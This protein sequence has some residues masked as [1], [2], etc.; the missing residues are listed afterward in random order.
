M[1]SDKYIISVPAH[2]SQR[3]LWKSKFIAEKQNLI[4]NKLVEIINIKILSLKA[5]Q[6]EDTKINDGDWNLT[7][8]SKKIYMK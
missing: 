3:R 4:A 2:K 8:K 7:K 6:V 5:V 1:T